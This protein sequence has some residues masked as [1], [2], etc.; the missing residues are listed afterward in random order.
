MI[1]N[2]N[3]WKAKTESAKLKIKA[4]ATE[5]VRRQAM[6]VLKEAV[7]VSPQFSGDYA[8]NWKLEVN[9]QEGSYDNKF[10]PP[11]YDWKAVPV[12]ERKQAGNV[13]VI[14]DSLEYSR[15]VILPYI[16]WNST[17]RLVNYSP[18]AQLL[19]SGQVTFRPEN[20]ISPPEGVVAYL[21]TKFKYLGKL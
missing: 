9:R 7:R 3:A 8:Y 6:I 18:T 21:N 2:I 5:Y 13:G 19:D 12:G 11:G 20:L 17:I 15:E 1:K 16:K 4:S 10:K 14:A